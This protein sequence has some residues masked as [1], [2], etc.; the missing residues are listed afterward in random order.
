MQSPNKVCFK[1]A[2]I[3]VDMVEEN[4]VEIDEFVWLSC[5]ILFYRINCSYAVDMQSTKM[6]IF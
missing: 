4:D 1:N 6:F 5:V 3:A 2:D